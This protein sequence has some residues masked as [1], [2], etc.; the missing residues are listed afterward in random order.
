MANIDTTQIEGFDGMTAEQKLEAV[1]KLNI[2][3]S[4]DMSKFVSKEVF[5]KKASEAADLSKQLKAKMTDDEAKKAAAEES[6]KKILEELETLRKEKTISDFTAKYIA[7]GY[8]KD[9]A[10]DTAKAMAEGDMDK[11]FKNGETHKTALE[12]KIKEDLMNKTPKPG[13]NG[14]NEHKAED[15]AVGKAKE[16]MHNRHGGEKEYDTIM[17]KYKK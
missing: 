2:P 17:S 13:G 15:A 12:K 10:I 1:L 7:L 8:D 9:L 11:V 3:E 14:G 6:N 4:V 5:D 16:I